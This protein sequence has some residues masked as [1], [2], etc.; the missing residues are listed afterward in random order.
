VC[1]ID[2]VISGGGGG[3]SWK[4]QPV[5]PSET[6]AATDRTPSKAAVACTWC[7]GR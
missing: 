2:G 7:P 6:A 3:G 1:K 5:G 4:Q